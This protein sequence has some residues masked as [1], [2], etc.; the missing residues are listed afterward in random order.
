MSGGDSATQ[1][2]R[3]YAQ[4]LSNCRYGELSALPAHGNGSNSSPFTSLVPCNWASRTTQ[5]QNSPWPFMLV[6]EIRVFR[7]DTKCKPPW[8]ALA[9][10][11]GGRHQST[12]SKQTRGESQTWRVL[13]KV[14][15]QNILPEC[16]VSAEMR[17]YRFIHTSSGQPTVFVSALTRT[18]QRGT[19]FWF[20]LTLLAVHEP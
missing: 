13:F 8:N 11:T 14:L 9:Y 5:L 1:K 10:E 18:R 3:E 20:F 6:K 2:A 19:V 16:V 12:K 7:G 15:A 4:V 17:R